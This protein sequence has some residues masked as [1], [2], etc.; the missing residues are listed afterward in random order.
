MEVALVKLGRAALELHVS[1][2]AGIAQGGEGV[3]QGGQPWLQESPSSFPFLAINTGA[4]CRLCCSV[5]CCAGSWA[6]GTP[7]L[8]V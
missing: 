8:I 7:L 3:G 1:P 5:Q 6:A 2:L 4:D